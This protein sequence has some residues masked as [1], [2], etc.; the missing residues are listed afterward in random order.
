M[1]PEHDHRVAV[2]GRRTAL[3][4]A[5]AGTHVAQVFF[6]EELAFEVVPVEAERSERDD[7][8]L[9]IGDRRSRSKP[10]VLM[11]SLMRQLGA[12]GLGPTLLAGLAIEAQHRE[13]LGPGRTIDHASP[14]SCTASPRA[15]GPIGWL[16]A[17]VRSL[18]SG[19]RPGG[20]GRENEDLIVPEDRCG[21]SSPRDSHLPLHMIGLAPL[22][23]WVGVGSHSVG[24]WAPPA[25]PLRCSIRLQREPGIRQAARERRDL[26]FPGVHELIERRWEWIGVTNSELPRDQSLR[27]SYC[28]ADG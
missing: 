26:K 2:E 7:Q 27:G 25:R 16:T 18:R 23:R 24:L 28:G 12:R 10:V 11:M 19:F 4:E 22:D 14:A 1:I 8:V 13:L 9:A 6:P 21:A 3:A 17:R 20:D 5:V 15:L